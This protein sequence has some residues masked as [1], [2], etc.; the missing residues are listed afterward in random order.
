MELRGD[1]TAPAL[2]PEAAAP[3]ATR[4]HIVD[5]LQA[6]GVLSQRWSRLGDGGAPMEHFTWSREAAEVFA[7]DRLR[8]FAVERDGRAGALA[9][10]VARGAAL[11]R[12]EA[13]GS[14]E[15]GEP[16]VAIHEDRAALREL[17]AALVRAG[18]TIYAE[19]VFADSAL[20]AELRA[21]CGTR[22]LAIIRPAPGCPR[23]LLDA[24]WRAP[25]RHPTVFRRADLRRKQRYAERLGAVTFE[26][27]AP[28][29]DRLEPLLDEAFRV[30]AA[31]WKGEAGS[32][33][34]RNPRLGAF[35]RKYARAA[36]ARGI[37]R[38]FFMRIDGR[39][40]A[41]VLAVECAGSLWTLKIGYDEAFRRCSPGALLT[42]H[43]IA[44]AA[45]RGLRSYEFL[46]T[47]AAW[48]RDWTRDER[49]CVS[50]RIYPLAPKGLAALAVDTFGWAR[51]KVLRR[52]AR[53]RRRA[54]TQAA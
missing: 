3:A 48:T 29:P 37:L 51:D 17:I 12:L 18:T 41:T 35:Y 52:L 38:L 9:P 34:A 14:Q 11:P 43:T 13:L 21:A 8:V 49:R 6:L 25:E 2:V 16:F 36:F 50:L 15:T 33:L 24:T 53:R 42:R 31:G 26:V 46:G 7:G 19:R 54:V 40:V 27:A 32:A 1:A 28:T 22:A 4:L 20:L 30:E 45:E 5:D 39:A 23:I 47:A 44:W 10:L